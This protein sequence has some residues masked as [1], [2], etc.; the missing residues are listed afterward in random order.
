[1][2][3][4]HTLPFPHVFYRLCTLKEKGC[5]TGIMSA[6]LNYA[7]RSVD[8]C[9]CSPSQTT[10]AN[11]SIRFNHLLTSC[12]IRCSKRI[13][14]VGISNNV[15]MLTEMNCLRQL[16]LSV[17]CCH[18]PIGFTLA[19]MRWFCG[20]SLQ[21]TK[22]IATITPRLFMRKRRVSDLLAKRYLSIPYLFL[23]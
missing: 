12:L 22:H 13:T 15:Q 23:L 11:G 9:Y 6:F 5:D 8:S 16:T 17:C 3:H 18:K 19:I 21:A 4:L 2:Q 10:S 20:P 14:A 1:M 7:R